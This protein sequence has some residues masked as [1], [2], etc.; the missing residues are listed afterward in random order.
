MHPY[1]SGTIPEK[2]FVG[3]IFL[4]SA[5]QKYSRSSDSRRIAAR[6]SSVS[7]RKSLFTHHVKLR[8]IKRQQRFFIPRGRFGKKG[9]VE[10]SALRQVQVVNNYDECQGESI[11]V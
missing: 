9:R 3:V 11:K 8:P 2:P 5:S 7:S 6:K 10:R 4:V 1:V